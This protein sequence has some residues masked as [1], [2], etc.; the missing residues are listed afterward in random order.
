MCSKIITTVKY[1]TVTVF[2][3]IW[4][5]LCYPNNVSIT[6]TRHT[7]PPTTRCLSGASVSDS[8]FRCQ[9][10][11]IPHL[12]MDVHHEMRKD[13]SL[14]AILFYHATLPFST[15]FEKLYSLIIFICLLY[16]M[17][18]VIQLSTHCLNNILDFP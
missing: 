3:E 7:Q 11:T 9:S 14:S 17:Q 5:I 13:I 18:T 1:F 8:C 12:S 4:L 15:R 2:K 16:I 10:T 6:L